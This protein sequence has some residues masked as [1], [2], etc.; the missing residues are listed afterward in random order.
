MSRTKELQL[1]EPLRLYNGEVILRFD[2]ANWNWYL[3]LPDGTL[4]KQSGVTGVCGIIDKSPYLVPWAAKM[5]YIKML[6][7]MPRTPEGRVA[8]ISWK[9]FDTLL[10]AAKNAHNDIK[11]EA[12]DVGHAAHKWIE[13]TIR[14]AIAFT[15]GVVEKM[16]DVSPTDERSVSCGLAAF[17]WMQ[18]HSARWICTERVVYSRKYKYAGTMDGLALVNSCSDPTCCSDEF[19]DKLAVI[20]WKSSNY[21]AVNYCYQTAAYLN[22]LNEEFLA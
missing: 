2:R 11:E 9:D 10:L 7:T 14:N 13:D 22:A 20:D 17:D 21:L 8:S 5:S 12:G 6:R 3:V 4:E 1:E 16:N 18:R 19:I 15:G